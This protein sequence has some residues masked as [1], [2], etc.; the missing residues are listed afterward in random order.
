M[1]E[2]EKP[3]AQ[4]RKFSQAQVSIRNYFEKAQREAFG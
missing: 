3:C 2:K 4:E 1:R